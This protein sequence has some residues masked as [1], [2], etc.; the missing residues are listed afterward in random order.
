MIVWIQS[1]LH[2]Y[3]YPKLHSGWA[4]V[5]TVY[6]SQ[7]KA[8]DSIGIPVEVTAKVTLSGCLRKMNWKK[9]IPFKLK[10][11]CKHWHGQKEGKEEISW[12]EE[13]PDPCSLSMQNAM[14]KGWLMNQQTWLTILVKL[15]HLSWYVIEKAILLA[16]K[17]ILDHV[18][19]WFEWNVVPYL[20][21]SGQKWVGHRHENSQ[22]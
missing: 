14:C 1:M 15:C 7:Y 6:F 19:S 10:Q 13:L 18:I 21:K 2:V 17:C 9:P 12:K 5:Y 11:T 16:F 22:V 4:S 8:V 20:V 3:C